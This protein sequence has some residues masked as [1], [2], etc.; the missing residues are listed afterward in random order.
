VLRVEAE[1]VERQG[2]LILRHSR[3]IAAAAQTLSAKIPAVADVVRKCNAQEIPANPC[4]TIHFLAGGGGGW[5]GPHGAGICVYGGSFPVRV[6]GHELTHSIA[7]PLP[8][9]FGEAWAIV[10]GQ[11]A[12]EAL[13][14]AA[15]ARAEYDNILRRLDQVDPRRTALDLMQSEKGPPN[16][17]YQHKAVWLLYECERRYGQDFMA[18]VLQLRDKQYGVR[19]PVNLTQLFRLFAQASGDPKF[20]GWL[21]SL[22]SSATAAS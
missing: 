12:G 6:L 3:P 16:L 21:K 17:D 5:A 1:I 11:K 9:I 15:D 2:P 14:D 8:G 20:Y 13:G 18:R 4:Y 22:G 7:N 19:K 10:V